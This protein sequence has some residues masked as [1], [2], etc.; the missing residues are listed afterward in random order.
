MK[1]SLAY[2][3]LPKP[4]RD[5]HLSLI[6]RF[7]FCTSKGC[8]EL[9]P[10][11][12]VYFQGSWSIIAVKSREKLLNNIQR[13]LLVRKPWHFKK[14]EKW[15]KRNIFLFLANMNK[16]WQKPQ[17]LCSSLKLWIVYFQP[18]IHNTCP[19][20]YRNSDVHEIFGL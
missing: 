8:S 10:Q 14:C 3:T 6:C 5:F 20:L 9:N 2:Q 15:W 11:I 12:W 17:F 16:F 18:Y 13:V 19:L 7:S 1:N 4:L